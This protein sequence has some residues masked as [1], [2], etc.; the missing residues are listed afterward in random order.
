MIGTT[1][2]PY[3]MQ[4]FI[5]MEVFEQPYNNVVA[6]RE[7][8]HKQRKLFA[9]VDVTPSICAIYITWHVNVARM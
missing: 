9:D 3:K 8:R 2:Y 4:C 7:W 5:C 6:I 1:R